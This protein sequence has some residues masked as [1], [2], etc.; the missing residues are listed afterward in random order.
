MDGCNLR[1]RRASRIDRR[2]VSFSMRS[3]FVLFTIVS[4]FWVV[5]WLSKVCC[6]WPPLARCMVRRRERVVVVCP[7]YV[8]LS[9]T[10]TGVVFNGLLKNSFIEFVIIRKLFC[11]KD[12][13]FFRCYRLRW[14][15]VCGRG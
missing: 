11:A 1:I 8:L 13:M 5:L 3:V 7:M 9:R 2:Y 12:L 15:G 6:F 4:V 14:S 10:S